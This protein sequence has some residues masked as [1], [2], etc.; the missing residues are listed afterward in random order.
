V[1]ERSSTYGLVHVAGAIWALVTG[2]ANAQNP[3][4][5]S[6][7]LYGVL[8]LGSMIMQRLALSSV[9]C[10]AMLLVFGA[11]AVAQTQITIGAS[12]G[13]SHFTA[14]GCPSASCV[15]VNLGTLSGNAFFELGGVAQPTGTFTLHITSFTVTSMNNG[16]TFTPTSSPTTSTFS[17]S[18]GTDSFSGTM[19][20][21]LIS[22]ET[23]SPRFVGTLT[24][25]ASAGPHA[26]TLWPVGATV[27]SDFTI[28]LGGNPV[29]GS[30]WTGGSTSS[31]GHMSSGQVLPSPEPTSMLLFGSGLLA[32]GAALR[33]RKGTAIA[34]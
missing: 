11:S 12:A 1:P 15:T 18:N 4:I 28:T 2:K 27:S 29:L 20:L 19:H 24:I 3:R 34:G 7:W 23:H 10:A 16:V 6:K 13:T 25:T 17:F 14:S 32:L 22:D 26:S 30:L 8:I 9:V 33:R 5:R 21:T 31:S